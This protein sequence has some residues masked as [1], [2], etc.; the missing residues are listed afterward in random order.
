MQSIMISWGGL[1]WWVCFGS[2][3]GQSWLSSPLPRASQCRWRTGRSPGR[4]RLPSRQSS[5]CRRYLGPSCLCSKQFTR[6][7]ELLVE[8]LAELTCLISHHGDGDCDRKLQNEDE[9]GDSVARAG[10]K[11]FSSKCNYQGNSKDEGYPSCNYKE[12]CKWVEVS[13]GIVC[14]IR[15][16]N[17]SWIAIFLEVNMPSS[18]N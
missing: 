9:D 18:C 5:V 10:G 2:R 15:S 3:R 4:R 11:F 12:G 8:Q 1:R 16:H 7:F 14:P 13:V 6:N 17:H